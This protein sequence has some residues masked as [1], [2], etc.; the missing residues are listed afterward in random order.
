[1]SFKKITVAAIVLGSL[2]L[3]LGATPADAKNCVRLCR[4]PIAHYR[5]T[6]CTKYKGRIR[7]LC[8]KEVRGDIMS[9]CFDEERTDICASI[10]E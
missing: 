9:W 4:K 2:G 8:R 3:G 6:V 1:V 7:V 10:F 5:K